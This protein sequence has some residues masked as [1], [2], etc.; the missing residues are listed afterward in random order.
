M[1]NIIFSFYLVLMIFLTGSTLFAQEDFSKEVI[2][3]F[4]QGAQRVGQTR[5]AIVDAQN[6]RAL[7]QKHNVHDEDVVAAF[8]DFVES[9]TVKI[10]PEG[11]QILQRFSGFVRRAQLSAMH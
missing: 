1:K 9:E 8:P 5:Q 6:I 7:L 2:V 4:T 10:T 11:N 3:Y